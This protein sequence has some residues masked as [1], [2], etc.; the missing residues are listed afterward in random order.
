MDNVYRYIFNRGRWDYIANA[1]YILQDA[2]DYTIEWQ[3]EK[4]VRDLFAV[5][6]INYFGSGILVTHELFIRE[7]MSRKLV[8]SKT[9]VVYYS[10]DVPHCL[11]KNVTVLPSSKIFYDR[12][13]ISKSVINKIIEISSKKGWEVV[14]TASYYFAE[15]TIDH[16]CGYKID[17]FIDENRKRKIDRRYGMKF[18]R[19]H[20]SRVENQRRKRQEMKDESGSI[21]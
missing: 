12:T 19:W 17:A 20:K 6:L 13:V 8:N 1:T 11:K 5:R 10:G 21:I 4:K 7:K 9:S 14:D 15:L 2:Y 3:G 16:I 18:V